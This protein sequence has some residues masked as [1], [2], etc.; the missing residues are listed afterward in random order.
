MSCCCIS[1]SSFSTQPFSWPSSSVRSTTRTMVA[2]LKRFFCA[3][4]NL[5][6]VS[7]VNVLPEPCVCQ[8]RPRF[9]LGSFAA[10]YD[11]VDRNSLVLAQYRLSR[12]T[13]FHVEQNPVLQGTQ[14]VSRLEE[15]LHGKLVGL[16]RFLFPACHGAA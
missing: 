8:T 14:E 10:F 9:L 12:F 5:A 6:A 15:G 7:R 16:F 4:I 13:I 2:F 11:L 3:R 1:P